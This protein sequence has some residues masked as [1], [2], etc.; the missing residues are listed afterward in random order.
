VENTI[1]CF[2]ALLAAASQRL[3]FVLL[4]WFGN[5]WIHEIL[6]EW[7]RKERGAAPGLVESTI[8][9]YVFGSNWHFAFPKNDILSLSITVVYE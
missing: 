7:Q 3:E 6:A 8:I 5:D 2:P 4:D 9:I 1:N